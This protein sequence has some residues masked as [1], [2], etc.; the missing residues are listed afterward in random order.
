[1]GILVFGFPV[2]AG[3]AML[4]STKLEAQK[5]DEALRLQTVEEQEFEATYGVKASTAD[6]IPVSPPP[7]PAKTPC[8]EDRAAIP[9]RGDTGTADSAF[10]LKAAET[11]IKDAR[12]CL[13][14]RDGSNFV[15]GIRFILK[16]L[17]D[18][19]CAE[20]GRKLGYGDVFFD[21]PRSLAAMPKPA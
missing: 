2:A 17:S 10:N 15:T 3:L 11:F 8:L 14:D 16:P 1:M 9:G 12:K 6:P 20:T 19:A 5:L 13:N 4:R 18:R 7:V 21:T